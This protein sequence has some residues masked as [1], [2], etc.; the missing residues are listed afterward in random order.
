[1][2]NT[3]GLQ[4][5]K[6]PGIA[7]IIF[8]SLNGAIGLL[9]LLGGLFRL[10][11]LGTRERL[12][13]DDAERVGYLIGTGVTYFVSFLSII[14]APV[15]IYGAIQMMKGA[16]RGLAKTAAIVAMLPVTSCCF[17][18]GIPLGIWALVVLGKP[19]VKAVFDGAAYGDNFF[20][21]Q[22]PGQW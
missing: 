12:P 14:L 1:M 4:K 17:I 6:G 2:T 10:S 18:L 13:S 9:S 22:P 19:E 21:P 16:K 8:G 11:G 15:V 7:L 3:D 20:P 5:L